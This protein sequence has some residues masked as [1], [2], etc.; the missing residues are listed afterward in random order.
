[1]ED[2]KK[3]AEEVS[4]LN[5]KIKL[6]SLKLK[7][8]KKQLIDLMVK[9]N[10]S[11]I[12]TNN[13]SI[14][15]STWKTRF[16]TQLK[17]EF[18]K[19][20]NKKKEEFLNKGL[21]KIQYKLDN[22]KFE[23]LKNKQEKTELDQYIIDRK[24]I[25][26]LTMRLKPQAKEILNQTEINLNSKEF[27][28]SEELDKSAVLRVGDEIDLGN[29]RFIQWDPEIDGEFDYEEWELE[30][31]ERERLGREEGGYDPGVARLGDDEDNEYPD[32]D[33]E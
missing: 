25:I 31:E 16:S 24:N 12:Q 9:K 7:K 15:K 8:I 23:E 32:D 2:H 14:I 19:L 5:L 11:R 33:E 22:K 18:N 27:S 28:E 13:S 26:F 10:I 29:G 17:K 21:L 1:M 4:K 6:D 3:L 20:E 30:E